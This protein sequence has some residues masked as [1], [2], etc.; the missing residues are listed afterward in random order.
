MLQIKSLD[1]SV[2]EL[3]NYLKGNVEMFDIYAKLFFAGIG[4]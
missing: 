3:K 4:E 1:F 2:D